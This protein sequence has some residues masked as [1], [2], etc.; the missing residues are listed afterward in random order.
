MECKDKSE[1]QNEVILRDTLI[2]EIRVKYYEDSVR[3]KLLRVSGHL[4]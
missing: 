1:M 4:L 3:E 2:Q